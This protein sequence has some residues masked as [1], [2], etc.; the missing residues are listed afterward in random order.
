MPQPM[1][2]LASALCADP[3]S[4]SLSHYPHDSE[5]NLCGADSPCAGHSLLLPP[6]TYRPDST[7]SR[8]TQDQC[9]A[10]PIVA[11]EG[12]LSDIAQLAGGPYPIPIPAIRDCDAYD[13]VYKPASAQ[14][15]SAGAP[16]S[17]PSSFEGYY[18]SPT[19]V[20]SSPPEAGGS[21]YWHHP[22]DPGAHGAG[23]PEP[24]THTTIHT[25]NFDPTAS[26]RY[27][28]ATEDHI[29]QLPAP[30]P[31]PGHCHPPLTPISLLSWQWAASGHHSPSRGLTGNID[32]GPVPFPMPVSEPV[33]ALQNCSID[34]QLCQRLNTP[35][36]AYYQGVPSPEQ[37]TIPGP[38]AAASVDTL[39]PF[40][41][42]ADLPPLAAFLSEA[43]SDSPKFSST[44][45]SSWDDHAESPDTISSAS[46]PPDLPPFH[47]SSELA[48]PTSSPSETSPRPPPLSS[49]IPPMLDSQR[50]G[51]GT[52]AGQGDVPADRKKYTCEMCGKGVY[53]SV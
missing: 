7:G 35:A 37:L 22:L 1:H 44:T 15:A 14:S 48:R 39:S 24:A 5:D 10:F 20:I 46:S 41:V 53:P 11:D 3:Y 21:L 12:E 19:T 30:Y 32:C 27:G 38:A 26:L 9:N 8:P 47:G 50:R 36:L 34:P 17:P 16:A 18:P 33:P 28:F 43:L 4:P 25:G 45:T 51:Q 2:I 52:V 23:F 31:L 29:G 49:E 13:T 42:D 6:S 40:D